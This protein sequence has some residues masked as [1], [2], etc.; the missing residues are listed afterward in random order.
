MRPETP[1]DRLLHSHPIWSIALKSGT[2]IYEMDLFIW[3]ICIMSFWHADVA[4]PV[5]PFLSFLPSGKLKY[6]INVPVSCVLDFSHNPKAKHICSN[7]QWKMCEYHK[8]LCLEMKWTNMLLS[9][10]KNK[11]S[12][13]IGFSLHCSRSFSLI[14]SQTLLSTWKKCWMTERK[15][16]RR[17]LN[18]KKGKKE[19]VSLIVKASSLA[20][21]NL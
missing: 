1:F 4:F 18:K 17:V 3:Y 21:L 20:N 14:Q 8:N 10:V 13:S 15:Y 16:E 2:V 19:Q 9:V 7:S 5:W 12:K 11:K 6:Q